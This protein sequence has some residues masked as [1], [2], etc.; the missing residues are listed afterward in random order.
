MIALNASE[1]HQ[2]LEAARAAGKPIAPFS[3]AHPDPRH[4]KSIRSQLFAQARG[5]FPRGSVP[6]GDPNRDRV[7]KLH[8]Y[9]GDLRNQH[10]IELLGGNVEGIAPGGESTPAEVSQ[11]AG[12]F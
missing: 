2:A 5:A 9:P 4:Y 12:A 3:I 10:L 11:A 6:R 8:D 1:A 7:R